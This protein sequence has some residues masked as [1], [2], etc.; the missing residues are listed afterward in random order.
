MI[1]GDRGDFVKNR[2]RDHDIDKDGFR[3][4]VGYSYLFDDF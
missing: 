3:G 4:F 1:L 2:D